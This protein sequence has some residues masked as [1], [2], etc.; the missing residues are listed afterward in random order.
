MGKR[1]ERGGGD[2]NKA[3][4]T[5]MLSWKGSHG[6]RDEGSYYWRTTKRRRRN[7]L[8]RTVLYYFHLDCSG[9]AT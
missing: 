5:G 7:T 6:R 2:E 9:A 3:C 4:W 1:V 8:K